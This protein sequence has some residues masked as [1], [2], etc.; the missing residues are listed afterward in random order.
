MVRPADHRRGRRRASRDPPPRPIGGKVAPE[1]FLVYSFAAFLTRGRPP[2]F[3]PSAERLADHRRGRFLVRQNWVPT[4]TSA[5][6]YTHGYICM[7]LHIYMYIDI[8][9]CTYIYIFPPSASTRTSRC[10]P[11]YR[12]TF[13]FAPTYT[14][15]FI[16]ETRFR[17]DTKLC[18][19]SMWREGRVGVHAGRYER[20]AVCI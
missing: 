11:I 10:T 20:A 18:Y 4:C 3:S 12:Y 7:H 15:T 5:A 14:P 16:F 17:F 6:T 1:G 8:Y 19:C 13:I 9:I 2:I